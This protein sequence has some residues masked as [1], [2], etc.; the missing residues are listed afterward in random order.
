MKPGKIIISAIFPFLLLGC[1]SKTPSTDLIHFD[2]DVAVNNPMQ[3]RMSDFILDIEYVPLE[4]RKEGII[5]RIGP[6][7]PTRKYL[8]TQG[9]EQEIFLFTQAGKFV[10]QIGRFGQGPGEYSNMA[11]H[12]TW[13]EKSKELVLFDQRSASLLFYTEDGQ[14]IRT[15]KLPVRPEWI[16]FLSHNDYLGYISSQIIDNDSISPY[17]FF[18]EEGKTEYL[19]VPERVDYSRR[20]KASFAPSIVNLKSGTYLKPALSD[21]IYE[22][23]DR[24]L[25]PFL[26]IDLGGNQVPVELFYDRMRFYRESK[27]YSFSGEISACGDEYLIL[28]VNI[29]NKWCKGI[30][31]FAN[32]NLS[33]I[34]KEDTDVD[35]GLAND[36]DGGPV[37]S[38]Y[39]NMINGKYYTCNSAYDL[40]SDR[41]KGRFAKAEVKWPEKQKA[42]LSMINGLKEDDNPVVQIMTHK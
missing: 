4:T 39:D 18:N 31:E 25:I 5:G 30:F 19:K 21:T 28:P 6:V 2:V 3:L 42:L 10:R 38:F 33:R 24:R 32:P 20:V 17:F 7:I 11:N 36:I 9:F 37:W 26:A 8:V 27:A 12:F 29:R 23:K 40:M 13:D 22:L 14:W 15:A 35:Y 34:V 1:A 16:Y 41:D